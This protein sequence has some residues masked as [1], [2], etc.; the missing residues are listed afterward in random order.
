MPL[1]AIPQY[2]A[3]ATSDARECSG[4]EMRSRRDDRPPMAHARLGAVLAGAVAGLAAL[5]AGAAAESFVPG[6]VVVGLEGGGAHVVE[7]E[8]GVEVSEAVADL[9]QDPRVAYANPNWVATAALSPLD[10]GRSGDPAGWRQDQWNFL[11]GAGG[12]RA[13]KAWDRA[14][15][16]GAP[17][18]AGTTVA[19][20]DTG[21]AYANSSKPPG[22]AASPDFAAGQFVEGYDFVKPGTDPLDENGHGTH[23]AG[24]IAEQVTVGAPAPQDFL[25]GLAYG[26]LLMPVRVLDA[27][28]AGNSVDVAAGILW[29][30]RNGAD[31]INVSLQLPTRVRRCKQ[32]RAVCR[33]TRKA[34]KLGALVVAA[35]G[36]S[37]GGGGRP[38]ALFP[39]QA[40]GVVSVAAGTEGGCLA[41]YS[42]FGQGVD[43][44][45]PGG[46]AAKASA[47]RRRCRDDSQAVR[48]VSFNCFPHGFCD[49]FLDFGIRPDIGTSMAAAHASGV[50]ALVRASQAVGA[51]PGPKRLRKRLRCTA[52]DA[53]PPRF[54]GAGLLD[55]ARATDPRKRCARR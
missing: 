7:L 40:P 29:A 55:A 33:A 17:G 45:A 24:T 44:V 46:G 39:A 50:A 47:E 43:L 25:T 21:I 48:Q 37:T 41:A 28:G 5:P 31:V 11:G 32:V 19:V 15:A 22:F 9:Q 42:N 54:Y 27:Q 20:V 6:E 23:V 52:R 1:I 3:A 8:P 34:K 36:N 53:R 14:I 30:A 26:A 2:G 12:I 18:A 35:A 13:P 38:R 4:W 10:R 51:D 16:A 49:D